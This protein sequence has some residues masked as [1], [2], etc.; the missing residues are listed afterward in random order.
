MESELT[1]MEEMT[2]A[3]LSYASMERQGVNLRLEKTDINQF[4]D[5]FCQGFQSLALQH[6]IQLNNQLLEQ[7]THLVIDQHWFYRAL[8]NLVSN[9]LQYANQQVKISLSIKSQSLVILIEDDG[10]GLDP[11][12][13]DVVFD[14]FVKL[15]VDRSREQ[16]HFGL[17]LAICAKVIDWH[18]GKISAQNSASLGGAQFTIRLPM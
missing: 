12:K 18:K 1:N 11:K 14:P 3:F 16:G 6:Q 15:D 2:T 7:N 10:K 9:A 4:I 13:F 5:T 8:Q 17:G